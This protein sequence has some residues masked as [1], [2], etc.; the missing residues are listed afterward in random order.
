MP[1]LQN[2][3]ATTQQDAELTSLTASLSQLKNTL[4]DFAQLLEQEL[5]LLQQFTPKALE[6]LTQTLSQKNQQIEL[7]QQQ[8]IQI[9]KTAEHNHQLSLSPEANPELN[10]KQLQQLPLTS[11]EQQLLQEILTLSDNLYQKNHQNGLLIQS[12]S[13]LNQQMLT[14]LKGKDPQYTEYTAQGTKQPPPS[15]TSILGKA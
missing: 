4:L 12:L 3:P 13:N 5:K 6:Q 14:L 10:L 9:F 7:L 8:T 2:H 15:Q 11:S 1:H